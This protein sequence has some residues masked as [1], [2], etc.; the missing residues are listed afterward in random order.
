MIPN[1]V[2]ILKSASHAEAARRFVD[3]V[4]R[5]E[6]E[7]ELA[8][9]RAA[10]VPVRASVPRPANVVDAQGFTP[11]KVDWRAVGQSV[12]ARTAELQELFLK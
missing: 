6:I 1:T 3:W 4:L 8:Q 2:S 11:M 10:Q 5:P 7:A 9:S 12:Q